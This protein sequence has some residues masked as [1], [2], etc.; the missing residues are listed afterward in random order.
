MI[1]GG[2]I[3][4]MWVGWSEGVRSHKNVSRKTKQRTRRRRRQWSNGVKK[5]E[6]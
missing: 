3:A 6:E 1:G 5:N 2:G 4:A